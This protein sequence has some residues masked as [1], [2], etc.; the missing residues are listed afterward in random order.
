MYNLS[1]NQAQRI[2]YDEA[3]A[4]YYAEQIKNFAQYA[5][6]GE[7]D[8]HT[9]NAWYSAD[10]AND[11][12]EA[13]ARSWAAFQLELLRAKMSAAEF[14]LT[15]PYARG[16]TAYISGDEDRGGYWVNFCQGM[17]PPHESERHHSLANLAEAN[18]NVLDFT[19]A[20]ASEAE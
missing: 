1:G 8:E 5:D 10:D 3:Q 15:V 13:R 19:R 2:S 18:A 20:Y 16:Y 11:A 6:L 9:F 4:R 14:G 12:A 7:I 17:M